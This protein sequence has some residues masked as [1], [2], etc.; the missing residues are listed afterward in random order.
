MSLPSRNPYSAAWYKDVKPG[1]RG[2]RPPAG[3]NSGCCRLLGFYATRRIRATSL[4]PMAG[5]RGMVLLVQ[6]P[7]I[8]MRYWRSA[9]V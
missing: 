7:N 4:R 1:R 5:P 6:L 3:G 9:D 2:T 8:P